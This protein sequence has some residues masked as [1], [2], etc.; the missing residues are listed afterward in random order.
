MNY[1]PAVAFLLGE[2]PDHKGRMVGE[3]ANFTKEE[4]ETQ[5]DVIQWAF[6]TRTQSAFNKDAPLLPDGEFDC[7]VLARQNLL[8]LLKRYLESLNIISMTSLSP[9]HL[10][11]YHYLNSHLYYNWVRRGNH[12]Y[13]RLTR[14]LESL[15]CFELDPFRDDLASFLVFDFAMQFSREIGAETVVYWVAAWQNK[16]GEVQ[17]DKLAHPR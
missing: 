8:V 3:Y 4:W 13:R 17:P 2:A 12:N 5:H 15:G 7:P 14:V 16:L 6:P 1:I 11:D 9:N 10:L